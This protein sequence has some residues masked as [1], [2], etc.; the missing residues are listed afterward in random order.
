MGKIS[1]ALSR[2]DTAV[3]LSML[4]QL[5]IGLELV[6]GKVKATEKEGGCYLKTAS[7]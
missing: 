3:P 2:E 1:L 7:Q 6:T 5:H 4:I